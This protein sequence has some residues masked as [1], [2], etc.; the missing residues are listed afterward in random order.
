MN[1]TPPA[2]GPLPLPSKNALVICAYCHLDGRLDTDLEVW[3]SRSVKT[4]YATRWTRCNVCGAMWR[5][6]Y[7]WN[8]HIFEYAEHWKPRE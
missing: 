8:Y 3:L 4:G 2:S 5:E 7:N 6:V 1:L